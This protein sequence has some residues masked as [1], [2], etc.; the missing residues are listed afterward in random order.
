MET[1]VY[2]AALLPRAKRNEVAK[3]RQNPLKI[4]LINAGY[5]IGAYRHHI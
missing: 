2:Q 4:R 5:F 1:L 3:P